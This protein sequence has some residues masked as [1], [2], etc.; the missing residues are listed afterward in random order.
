MKMAAS[1]PVYD[2]AQLRTP[3]VSELRNLWVYRGLIR[4][5]VT[6]DLTTRYKR[7]VL[8]VWWTLLN[9]LLTTGV[10]WLVFGVVIGSRFGQTSE[11]YVVY[12]LSGVIMMTFFSQGFLATAAAIAGAGGILTKVYVPAE[13]FAFATAISAAVNFLI[14]FGA[15]VLV[16]LWA[17]VG[18]PPSFLLVPV[19]IILMLS[20]I[21]GLGLTLAALAVYFYDIL[22]LS[23][24]L[25]QLVYYLTPV[26]WTLAIVPERLHW[27]MRAN[28]L[29]SY[30]E[31]FRDLGYRGVIP[32]TWMWL[33]TASTSLVFLGVGVWLFGRSW[34]T[35]VSQL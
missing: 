34:K 1:L 24:V 14:S 31:M 9:P 21:V 7:S 23:R 26:F 10:M 29:F 4:L 11:P 30:L 16:Q 20:L 19:P 22:D 6:R 2:S 13:V 5:L 33:V 25:V 28:P 8:G 3:I 18:I 17:G 15:L 27:A 32:P 35:L 12:L